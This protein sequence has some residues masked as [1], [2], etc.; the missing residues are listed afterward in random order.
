M[1]ENNLEIL[2]TYFKLMTTN[3]SAY[4][5]NIAQRM[6]FFAPFK[7]Q[8]KLTVDEVASHLGYKVRGVKLVLETLVSLNV[9][10]KNDGVFC[11][12]PVTKLLTGNYENLSSDYWEHLPMFLQTGTPYKKMDKVT[13]S[14]LEYQTQVKSLEWMMRPCAKLATDLIK[15]SED[16]RILD[17]GAGSGVWSYAFLNKYK[18]VNA[19]LVDWPAVLKVA[20]Q[21]AQELNIVDRV[22]F[23]ESN[24]HEAKL[25]MN[26][27]DLAILGNVTHIETEQGNKDLFS[28]ISSSLKS[29]GK[30]AI[31]DCYS[32]NKEG[33]VSRCLYELGLAIRTEQGKVHSVATLTSW[34]E[35]FEFS[36]FDFKSIDVTPYTMGVLVATKK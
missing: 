14:E 23:V 6:N 32:E 16:A 9:L 24:Y 7:N 8:D 33:E 18:N 36:K 30:L 27:Y 26:E 3:G 5:F 31:F 13:D 35:E 15:I 29:G 19:T 10:E 4:V 22:E 17:I 2:D 1:S 12:A 20:R 34:L 28:K 21:S 11:L 25:S